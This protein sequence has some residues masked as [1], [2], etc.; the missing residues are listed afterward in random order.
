MNKRY[1]ED[2]LILLTMKI[3]LASVMLL[4]LCSNVIAKMSL[5]GFKIVTRALLLGAFSDNDDFCNDGY[6]DI[7]ELYGLILPPSFICDLVAETRSELY[8][9]CIG[10]KVLIVTFNNLE[11]HIWNSGDRDDFEL[12]LE[13]EIFDEDDAPLPSNPIPR[14][15][16]CVFYFHYLRCLIYKQCDGL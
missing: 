13:Y 12:G 3:T 2:N 9:S 15:D 10:D 14:Y 8:F 16:D 6:V 1:L 11:E 5:D 7:G 4:A